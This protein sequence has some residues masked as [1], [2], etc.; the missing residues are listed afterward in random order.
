MEPPRVNLYGLVP[1]TYRRYVVQSV[2]EWVGL[3]ALLAAWFWGWPILA[4]RLAP[5]QLPPTM[6]V[7]MAI[8]RNVPWLV[9]GL[10]VFKCIEMYFVLRAFRR[11]AIP[12]TSTTP[13]SST[14]GQTPLSPLPGPGTGGQTPDS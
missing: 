11:K 7:I 12:S 1:V 3:V 2:I 13:G 5:H 10:A 6:T 8:L 9:L 14:D 4:K